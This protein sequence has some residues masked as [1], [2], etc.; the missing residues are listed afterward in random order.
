MD[1]QS[2]P[3]PA[4]TASRVERGG[5]RRASSAPAC[6]VARWLV[7]ALLGAAALVPPRSAGAAVVVDEDVQTM[8]A[9]ADVVARVLVVDAYQSRGARGRVVTWSRLAVL[10]GIKGAQTGATLWLAQPGGA[11]DG[12]VAAVQ[13]SPRLEVGRELVVFA[14]RHRDVLV[15]YALGLGVFEVRRDGAEA[16]VVEQVTPGTRVARPSAASPRPHG[17]EPPRAPAPRWASSLRAFE[18]IVRLGATARRRR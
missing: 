7:A 12:E 5:R 14:D 17:D 9:R 3:A 13:G 10:D 4:P 1:C 15:L 6:R 11:V 8:A 18:D 16:R 2:R